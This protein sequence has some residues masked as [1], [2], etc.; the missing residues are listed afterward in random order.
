M[1]ENMGVFNTQ[2]PEDNVPE[3]KSM[4][5]E[6]PPISDKEQRVGVF[7][8]VQN[9]YYSARLTRKAK[10]NYEALLDHLQNDRYLV[11][12]VAYLL[13][14]ESVDQKAF[15]GALKAIGYDV[16]VKYLKMREGDTD[17]RPAKG[18][19]KVEMPLEIYSI[20]ARLDAVVLVT[21]NGD[22]APLLEYLRKLGVRV[23]VAG[24]EGNTSAELIKLADEFIPIPDDVLVHEKKFDAPPVQR[25]SE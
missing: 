11:R 6:E 14:K 3:I 8:D 7:V 5:P 24:F 20:A 4:A 19:W 22:Y 1:V 23:E 12:A 10:I 2:D 21:G 18:D 13:N 16:R 17:D 25:T 9:M 15:I